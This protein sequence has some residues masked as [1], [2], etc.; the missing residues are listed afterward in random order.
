MAHQ[1]ERDWLKLACELFAA[2]YDALSLQSEAIRYDIAAIM[3]RLVVTLMIGI[4]IVL[5]IVIAISFA[6]MALAHLIAQYYGWPLALSFI[7]ILYLLVAVVITVVRPVLP[8]RGKTNFPQSAHV[9]YTLKKSIDFGSLG[10]NK[11]GKVT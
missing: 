10:K 6:S 9:F 2:L 11:D 8:R 7:S 4:L 3:R 5:L 1:D